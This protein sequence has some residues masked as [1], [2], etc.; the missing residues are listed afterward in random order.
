MTTET[1]K[2]R[3]EL[4]TQLI[5]SSLNSSNRDNDCVENNAPSKTQIQIQQNLLYPNDN[6]T[7]ILL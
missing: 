3:A 6:E 5:D 7:K 4:I 1:A 2:A